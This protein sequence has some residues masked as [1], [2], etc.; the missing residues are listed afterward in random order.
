[1]SVIS[2]ANLLVWFS[3]VL[4]RYAMVIWTKGAGQVKGG[5]LVITNEVVRPLRL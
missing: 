5:T 3:T 2:I 1:M 4:C